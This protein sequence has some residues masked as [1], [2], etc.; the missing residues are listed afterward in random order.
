MGRLKLHQ[1]LT[2]AALRERV[3]T[4]C[5][6]RVQDQR[7]ALLWRMREIA[8]E[9]SSARDV[10]ATVIADVTGDIQ[11]AQSSQTATPPGSCDQDMLPADPIA[12]LGQAGNAPWGDGAAQ[13]LSGDCFTVAAQGTNSVHQ[14]SRPD[15]C[16]NDDV[17][18]L[19]MMERALYEDVLRAQADE[20]AADEAAAIDA[21][22][23]MHLASPSE[24]GVPCP[25]CAQA[26]L[27]ERAGVIACPRGDL[28]L[29]LR[30]EGLG[31]E[32]LRAC[33]A[34]AYDAHAGSGCGAAPTFA[35]QEFIRGGPYTLLMSCAACGALQ[36][37]V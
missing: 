30:A 27:A 23:D 2:P 1:A 31:L 8:S 16:P 33:L 14:G 12:A 5:L 25:V 26:W 7:T 34:D 17:E 32:H 18:L 24:A 19:L 11:S 20:A 36:V 10:L 28:M 37:I 29:D 9:G 35:P 4:E 22:V 15:Y 6:Q 3:R 21:M 13:A